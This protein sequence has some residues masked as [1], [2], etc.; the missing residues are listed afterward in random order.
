MTSPE[1][2]IQRILKCR[3]L[4]MI[5]GI[6]VQVLQLTQDPDVCIAD[7]IE[8]M[9]R[10][11][12]LAGRV[13]RAANLMV[14]QD[15]PSLARAVVL[16]GM[17]RVSTL[18]LGVSLS[19]TFGQK[20]S[21]SEALEVVWRR[22]LYSAL[23]GRML[24]EE[25]R[26][27]VE[28]EVFLGSLFQDV[29]MLGMFAAMGQEYDELFQRAE[30]HELLVD[31]EQ[32]VLG[33]DH[34]RVGAAMAEAWSLP[35]QLTAA[36]ACH[37]CPEDAAEETQLLARLVWGSR[38]AANVLLASDTDEA[39][40]VAR[41]ALGAHFGLGAEQIPRLLARLA[42]EA[43]ELAELFDVEVLSEGDTERILAQAQ[44]AL[45]Q[46][47]LD[48]DAEA[49]HLRGLNR[50]LTETAG[51]D[52]LTGLHNRTR[53]EEVMH[54]MFDQAAENGEPLAVL[55]IDA[56]RFKSVND[57][58]GHG[59]GDEVLRRIGQ[60]V[61]RFC[62]DN[63]FRY[64]GEEI[65]CLLPGLDTTQAVTLAENIRRATESEE[66][67]TGDCLVH[68][69]LSVGVAVACGEGSPAS[70]EELTAAADQA[71][72]AAKGGGR[73]RVCVGET[74]PTACE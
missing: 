71:L 62:G 18:A 69:T 68:V 72:Y 19:A 23:A 25:I 43:E 26:A 11:P 6:S 54:P 60:V 64:G 61:S 56:D 16:L 36:I 24:A 67:D 22:S 4:P 35:R 13:L 63:A 3:R 34:A 7:I 57:M 42:H 47:A 32:R 45:L 65:L 5:P 8:V 58:Y 70:L 74:A 59:V 73:N 39:T 38:V 50:E 20:E 21:R 12:V 33:T 46:A 52:A 1:E 15:V 29:G 28:D 40:Y 55:F 17:R 53:L 51:R 9:G 44:D 41:I 30:D 66:V 48:A 37:H 27:G 31:I 49:Q 2:L 14:P 10:D